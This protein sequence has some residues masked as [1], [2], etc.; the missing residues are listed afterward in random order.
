MVQPE[1]APHYG[2]AMFLTLNRQKSSVA[3]KMTVADVHDVSAV[4]PITG[5]PDMT[6][7]L[8]K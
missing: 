2:A 6:P 3:N 8:F 5:G 4:E 1:A 7:S